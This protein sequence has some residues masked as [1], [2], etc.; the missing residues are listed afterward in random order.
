[1][2]HWGMLG[3][4]MTTLNL[5]ESKELI[6]LYETLTLAVE[7]AS[8][9]MHMHGMDSGKFAAEDAKCVEIWNRI[10][11]LIEKKSA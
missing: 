6:R 2:S 9:I 7:R 1:M 5:G 4:V 3:F 8:S 11:T 10:R